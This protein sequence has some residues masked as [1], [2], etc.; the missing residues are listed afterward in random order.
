MSSTVGWKNAGDGPVWLP[1]LNAAEIQFGIPTDLLARIAYQ[2][3]HFRND[4]ITG[5]TASPA[6]ALGIMQLMPQFFTSVR[7]ARP[8]Q[9]SD[10]LAQ[11]QEAAQLLANDFATL[12]DWSQAV[13]A[14]NAGLGTIQKGNASAANAAG[15]AAYVAA[16]LVDVPAAQSA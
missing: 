4:I 2:E 10:T 9:Q 11:I 12:Q 14:Y 16:I 7:V 13:A 8:F 15:T 6:G 5:A 3:S 1:A